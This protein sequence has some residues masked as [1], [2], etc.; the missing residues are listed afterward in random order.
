MKSNEIKK[1]RDIFNAE[2][3]SFS[4]SIFNQLLKHTQGDCF[5]ILTK[6]ILSFLDDHFEDYPVDW[7]EDYQ[8]A[9]GETVY[10]T[11][12]GKSIF[13]LNILKEQIK[14]AENPENYLSFYTF[15]DLES[16]I[17]GASHNNGFIGII[18][19]FSHVEY[20]TFEDLFIY[21]ILKMKNL[22]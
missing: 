9:I 13:P 16:G 22:K 12:H 1:L 11:Y 14:E 7:I 10:I 20:D 15:T 8:Y 17:N 3:V 18:D 5:V 4:D 21:S 2:I 6:D 19:T